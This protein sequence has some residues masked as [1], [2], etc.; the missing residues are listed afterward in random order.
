MGVKNKLLKFYYILSGHI[1]LH[2][3]TT[4][5]NRS[6]VFVSWSGS[7]FIYFRY[8]LSKKFTILVYEKWFKFV[9]LTNYWDTSINLQARLSQLN[10][11]PNCIFVLS[12]MTDGD[13]HQ[14]TRRKR[15][16]LKNELG[17]KHIK[18][19]Q[20]NFSLIFMK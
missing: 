13:R 2:A 18:G 4:I 19:T 11:S 8:E 20:I 12:E 17:Q 9:Y 16:P 15:F 14:R 1:L 5:F 7:N 10:R 6:L 3:K